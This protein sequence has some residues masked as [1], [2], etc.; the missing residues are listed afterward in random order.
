MVEEGEASPGCALCGV[1]FHTVPDTSVTRSGTLIH[2]PVPIEAT[3]T[4]RSGVQSQTINEGAVLVDV[5]TGS[6]FELNPIGAEV[7]ALLISGNTLVGI[8][9]ALGKHYVV[10]RSVLEADVRQLVESLTS[11]GL[12]EI[13]SQNPCATETP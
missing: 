1:G 2:V 10:E 12:V 11:A 5:Q 8:C 6:V 4:P 7:W 9:D 13:G 3:I